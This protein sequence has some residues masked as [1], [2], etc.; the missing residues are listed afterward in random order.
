M[1][2]TRFITSV[3]VSRPRSRRAS[4]I[5]AS[6]SSRRFKARDIFARARLR[7]R[8]VH[9]PASRRWLPSSLPTSARRTPQ[10]TRVKRIIASVS[11]ASSSSLKSPARAS[12]QTFPSHRAR[13]RDRARVVARVRPPPRSP[14]RPRRKETRRIVRASFALPPPFAG[15]PIAPIITPR[16]V[17]Y[18]AR[19]SIVARVR[20]PLVARAPAP[21]STDRRWNHRKSATACS[22]STSAPSTPP[23]PPAPPSR[24][25]PRRGS[26]SIVARSSIVACA[27]RSR[28]SRAASARS[29]RWQTSS[30]VASA[31]FGGGCVVRAR[32]PRKRRP[33]A[34]ARDTPGARDTPRARRMVR[35]ARR[36]LLISPVVENITKYD[37]ENTAK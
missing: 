20:R 23:A 37:E 16:F 1:Q 12:R 29:W 3:A 7:A 15:A 22:G 13:S 33:R 19:A 30:C 17:A 11:L 26:P 8:L 24:P 18:P 35:S 36:V 21:F 2:N 31:K 6:S 27:S 5:F 25:P 28:P 4:P 32:V 14:A 34:I 10:P 9:A